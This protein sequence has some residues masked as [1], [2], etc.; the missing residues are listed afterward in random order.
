MLHCVPGLRVSAASLGSEVLL[1]PAGAAVVAVIGAEGALA[2][3]TVVTGEAVA[4]A[5]G[6]VARAL[7]GALG[8][9]VQVVR[10]HDITNPGK[11]LRTGAKR[12]VGSGPLGLTV[13]AGKALAV[14]VGFAGSV[15]GAVVLA[16]AALA[17]SSLVEGDLAPGLSLVG[18]SG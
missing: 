13:E 9:R 11:V 6:A 1:G 3:N 12:A 15:V 5:G 18:G 10:V 14:V 8:P 16:H 4:G 2:S 17:V 7:V